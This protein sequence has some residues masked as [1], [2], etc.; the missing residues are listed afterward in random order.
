MAKKKPPVSQSRT[1]WVKKGT[2]VNG[3]AVKK[4]YVAQYGKPEKRV[5]NRVK[6]EV[7]TPKRGKKGDV[8]TL[9]AGRYVTKKP[10]SGATGGTSTGGAKATPAKPKGQTMAQAGAS[11]GRRQ[12]AMAADR[13]AS[14]TMTSTPSKV[15]TAAGPK[16]R[17]RPP[18][19]SAAASKQV[20]GLQRD[21]QIGERF[22]NAPASG[23]RVVDSLEGVRG[24]R[25]GEFRL[26]KNR[27]YVWNGSRWLPAKGPK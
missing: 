16:G 19:A 6:L 8:V 4:G 25:P 14:S 15:N 10:G 3:E 7:D 17:Y 5:T 20:A 13:K 24:S 23:V 18:A 1:M 12:A 2:V 11:A 22:G 26:M 21:R 9:K 27:F